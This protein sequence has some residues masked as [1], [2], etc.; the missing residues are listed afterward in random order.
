VT[1]TSGNAHAEYSRRL[2]VQSGVVAEFE[3]RHVALGN[4]QLAVAAAGVLAVWLTLARH[5]FP[6]WWL[7]APAVGFVALA[8]VHERVIRARKRAE[9]LAGF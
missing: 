8:L 1:E 5:W 9:R 4:A 7:L 3:R 2:K 6:P